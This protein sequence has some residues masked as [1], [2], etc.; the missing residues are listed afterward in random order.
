M[1]EEFCCLL[2]VYAGDDPAHLHAALNSIF[3]QTLKPN[4]VVLVID[5]PITVD[6]EQVIAKFTQCVCLRLPSNVGRG[7]ALRI[8]IESSHYEYI[9]LM[10]ADDLARKDR[11]YLQAKYMSEFPDCVLLGGCISEFHAQPHDSIAIRK[12]PLT[13]SDIRHFAFWRNPFNQMTVMFKRSAVL[14]AGNYR[15][16]R[17]FE[18]Y[19]LFLRMLSEGGRVANLEDVLVDARVGN[20]M[21]GR[22]I[23]VEYAKREMKFLWRLYSEGHIGF[24]RLIAMLSTRIPF[25]LIP[26]QLLTVFYERVLRK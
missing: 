8:A 21:I 6:L 5:G 17:N 10:D 9:A 19:D 16:A 2:S 20:D 24:A 3:E 22:R 15:D 18:D 1:V 13:D 23:G 26:K 7:P 11:F 12:V 14:N 25:R 4:D